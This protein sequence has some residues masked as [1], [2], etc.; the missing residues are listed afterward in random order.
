MEVMKIRFLWEILKKKWE[1]NENIFDS[2]MF[3]VNNLITSMFNCCFWKEL[4]FFLERK[5]NVPEY[6]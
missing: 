4:L 3:F 1:E 2:F 6:G 5:D